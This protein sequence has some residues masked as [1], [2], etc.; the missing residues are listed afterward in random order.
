MKTQKAKEGYLLIDHRGVIGMTTIGGKEIPNN[1][2]IERSTITCSHCQRVVIINPDRLRAR[3][4]CPKCDHYICDECESQRVLTGNC[5][6]FNEI[7]ERTQE[8]ALKGVFHG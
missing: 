2:L 8:L 3:H 6:T 1:S 4:Y 7:I 5:I